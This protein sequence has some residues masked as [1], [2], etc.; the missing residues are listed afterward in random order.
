MTNY[1]LVTKKE[2][3]LKG[4]IIG[5]IERIR[6]CCVESGTFKSK[7]MNIHKECKELGLQSPSKKTVKRRLG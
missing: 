5:N 4:N 2:I 7:C 6:I 1:R 3:D